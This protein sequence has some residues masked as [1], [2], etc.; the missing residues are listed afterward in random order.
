[1]GEVELPNPQQNRPF[2]R[3][4]TATSPGM[5]TKK[6][7]DAKVL[8]D[9]GSGTLGG[10]RAE[11]SAR[12]REL[13]RKRS[14]RLPQWIMSLIRR[15][16]AC[17]C[18]RMR[19]NNASFRFSLLFLAVAIVYSG[20]Y[21]YD[22]PGI[23]SDELKHVIGLSNTQLGMLFSV[24]AFPNA[25][26]PLVSGTVM[27]VIGVW[28][29][30]LIIGTVIACGITVVSLGVYMQSYFIMLLGRALYGLG[31]ESLFVGASSM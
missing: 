8:T 9:G 30:V 2:R 14:M 23:T 28:R 13:Q 21:S 10:G 7:D 26:M 3:L 6:R 15:G 16:R 17:F 18:P 11:L 22:L 20:Y 12:D 27:S 24:Y 1:M 4:L 5:S 19:P 29:G 25:V 31:G